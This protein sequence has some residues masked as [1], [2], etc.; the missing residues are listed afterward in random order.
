M[1]KSLAHVGAAVTSVILALGL[2]WMPFGSGLLIAG[3][4]AMIVGAEI[5]RRGGGPA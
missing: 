3:V 5:E 4:G 2:I 1:L